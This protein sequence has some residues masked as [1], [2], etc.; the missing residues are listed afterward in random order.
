MGAI[1]EIHFALS[2]S[3]Y[4]RLSCILN[5]FDRGKTVTF[6]GLIREKCHGAGTEYR[7]S[8]SNGSVENRFSRFQPRSIIH[9]EESIFLLCH[10]ADIRTSG[11][12]RINAEWIFALENV[13]E[14]I[15]FFPSVTERSEA[16][17]RL[18]EK[19]RIVTERISAATNGTE[20]CGLIEPLRKKPL[21]GYILTLYTSL[22]IS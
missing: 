8:G 2:K 19:P 9:T 21:R 18:W 20:G 15:G 14:R 1:Q 11:N 12:S 3:F 5:Y 16:D 22:E 17:I 6:S 7:L 4:G 10:G 13:T